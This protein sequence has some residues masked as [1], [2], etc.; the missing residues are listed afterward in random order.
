MENRIEPNCP[1]TVDRKKTNPRKKKSRR[2]AQAITAAITAQGLSLVFQGRQICENLSFT[3]P[4]GSISVL[5]PQN[6]LAKSALFELLAGRIRPEAGQCRI[7]PNEIHDLPLEIRRRIAVLENTERPYEV[8]TVGQ[9]AMFF[10][11]C[12]PAWS[13]ERYYEL[14]EEFGLTKRMKISN[15]AIHQRTLVALAVL[16]ARNPDLLIL[17]DWLAGFSPATR[18]IINR[19]LHRFRGQSGGTTIL[20]GQHLGLSPDLV[21]NLVLVGYS[22]CLTLPT[23]QLRDTF[24]GLPGSRGSRPREVPRCSDSSAGRAS[25]PAHG[26]H[27]GKS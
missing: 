6:A 10:S 5:V 23:A 18:D 27:A 13:N 15:L 3:L 2:T 1:R 25:S 20:V 4:R 12:F 17:D 9:T 16:L 11:G 7:G 14:I 21:D 24:P 22:T 19:A 8:M 26:R